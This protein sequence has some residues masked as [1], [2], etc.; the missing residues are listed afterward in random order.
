MAHNFF[1]RHDHC[2]GSVLLPGIV[3]LPAT[4]FFIME[5][6]NDVLAVL[7]YMGG[8]ENRAILWLIKRPG[9]HMSWLTSNVLT[10]R[11]LSDVHPVWRVKPSRGL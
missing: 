5:Y 3:E 7:H 1:Q 11:I 8:C 9:T 2:I 6:V 10:V 4:I